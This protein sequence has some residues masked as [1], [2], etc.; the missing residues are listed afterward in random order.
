MGVMV[1]FALRVAG[2]EPLGVDAA[3]L[4][5]NCVALD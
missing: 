2:K 3:S 4:I 5:A 1:P